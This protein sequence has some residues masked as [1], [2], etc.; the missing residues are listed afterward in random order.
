MIVRPALSEKDKR[1]ARRAAAERS[2]QRRLANGD[3]RCVCRG[4]GN[5]P[6]KPNC[7]IC[8]GSGLI[9]KARLV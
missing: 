4:P 7:R 2:R 5:G 6:A 3:T 8:G 1:T 9:T